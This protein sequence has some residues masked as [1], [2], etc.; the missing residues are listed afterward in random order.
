MN[1]LDVGQYDAE[2]DLIVIEG[3]TYSGCF[4]RELGC[5][6]PAMI[7]Q[8]LRVDRKDGGVVTVTRLPEGEQ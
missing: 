5:S 2:R 4:F 7:G 3:T 8:V 6:F 1:K